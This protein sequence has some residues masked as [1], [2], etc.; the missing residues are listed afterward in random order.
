M[1]HK[2]NASRAACI[3]LTLLVTAVRSAPLARSLDIAGR[4]KGDLP[5]KPILLFKPP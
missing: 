1:V 2:P 3:W 4:A 5:K